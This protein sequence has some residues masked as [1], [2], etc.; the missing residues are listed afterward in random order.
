M[1]NGVDALALIQ[2]HEM[3]PEKYNKFKQDDAYKNLT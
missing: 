3:T 1:I 2:D